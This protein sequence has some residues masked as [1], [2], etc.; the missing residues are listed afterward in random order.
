M[1]AFLI[2]N[3]S[4]TAL[5]YAVALLSRRDYS[6]VKLISKLI[7][8]DY[9]DS[10]IEEAIN[11][12]VERKLFCEDHYIEA[13]IKGLAKKSYS[14]LLIKQ[15]LYLEDLHI[16]LPSIR[17]IFEQEHIDE[18]ELINK[19]IKKKIRLKPDCSKQNLFLFL[20][21]KG[22]DSELIQECLSNF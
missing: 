13:R 20:R 22:Y 2:R 12:L 18:R 6:R 3:S 16:D 17:N 1:G 5:Q 7:A 10:E 4:Q 21:S 9:S 11:K 14:P 19:L 15:R 8:K